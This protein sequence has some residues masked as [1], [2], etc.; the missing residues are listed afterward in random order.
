[1]N[2]LITYD[3]SEGHPDRHEE[4]KNEMINKGYRKSYKRG[5]LYY[6][7]PNTTLWK[8]DEANVL[9]TQT[10]LDD[11][12]N[13]L[14]TVNHKHPL[15]IRPMRIERAECTDFVTHSGIPRNG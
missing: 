2:I 3:I 13:A 14:D 5:E 10:G 7:L 15:Q 9:T 4:I 8:K 1:M 6:D 11:L 12:Q